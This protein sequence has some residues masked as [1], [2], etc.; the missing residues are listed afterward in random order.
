MINKETAAGIGMGITGGIIGNIFVTSLFG[1]LTGV[2]G[3]DMSQLVTVIVYGVLLAVAIGCLIY[4]LGPLLT[5][6]KTGTDE[7]P[8]SPPAAITQS[9]PAPLPTKQE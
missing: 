7:I 8:S 6:I 3:R 9:E 4:I 2:F 1:F 5:L